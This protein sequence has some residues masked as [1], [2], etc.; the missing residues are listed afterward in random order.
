M[1][2]LVCLALASGRTRGFGIPSSS[3]HGS[4]SRSN[5]FDWSTPSMQ[6]EAS[7]SLS[8]DSDEVEAR[9]GRPVF[10][11]KISEL[12]KDPPGLFEQ[13]NEEGEES[14]GE[15]GGQPKPERIFK[16]YNSQELDELASDI[17]EACKPLVEEA[18][19]HERKIRPDIDAWER[20]ITPIPKPIP[21]SPHLSPFPPPR[22]SFPPP[23]FPACLPSLISSSTLHFF[24]SSHPPRPPPPCPLKLTS[25]PRT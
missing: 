9:K 23:P 3:S 24:F 14:T 10:P 7:T 22:A 20:Y 19:E 21:P 11:G 17:I 25:Q 12:R 18:N 6:M 15:E 4:S 16:D 1:L 2:W 8:S 5:S 13:V